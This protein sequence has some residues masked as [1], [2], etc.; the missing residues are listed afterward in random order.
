MDIYQWIGF[1]GT[2]L[3]AW[4]YFILQMGKYTIDS[5]PYQI[6]NLVGA[7]LLIISLFVHFNF[8]SFMM[9][10]FWISITIYGIYKIVK[11][12]SKKT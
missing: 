2:L 11:N 7:I 8:G 10:I 3:I 12:R 6:L 5:L 4:A 9:E 1:A